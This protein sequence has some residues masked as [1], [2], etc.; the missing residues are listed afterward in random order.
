MAKGTAGSLTVS[1]GLDAVEYTR[2]L[3][4]AEYQARQLGE[5]I[6][7]SIRAGAEIAAASFATMATSAVAA[8]ATFDNLVK[9]AGD[10]QDLAEKTGASAEG[11]ASFG[12]A[13]GTAGTSVEAIAQASIKL[14]K[15]LTGVD[16]ESKAAGAAVVALGLNLKDFK[17]LSPEDQISE[18][19]KALGGFQDGAGKT[20]V[21]TALL[22][23]SGADLLPFLKALEEQGGRQVILT[24]E[25]IKQADE[26]ADQQAKAKAEL[27]QY[28]QALATQA[29]PA[30]TAFTGA[31]T[32]TIKEM[33]GIEEGAGNLAKNKGIQEF[34]DDAAVFLGGVIDLG[35]KTA[36]VF[37]FL[38]ESIGATAAIVAAASR[39]SSEGA[40]AAFSFSPLDA[41]EAA[42]RQVTEINAIIDAARERGKKFTAESVSVADQV[43]NR[44]AE[45]KRNAV[46]AAQETR[47]FTP[48]Q[49]KL[50]FDGA[51][52]DDKGKKA[53][54]SEAQRYLE[55]L[56]KQLLKA[57][58][59]TVAETALAEIRSGRIGKVSSQQEGAILAVAR[60]V[61]ATKAMTKYEELSAA[62]A[63]SRG[64]ELLKATL[65]QEEQ[66]ASLLK[67]N[68]AMRDE[69]ELIGKSAESQA[70]IEQARLSSAIAIKEEEL[71]RISNTDS[72]VRERDAIQKQIEALTE[73]KR[74]VGE[75][76]V[77]QQLEE[78]SKQ[79]AEYAKSLGSAFESSFEKV[80]FS[81][82]KV[83]DVLKA[84]LQDIGRVILRLQVTQPLIDSLTKGSSGGSSGGSS[85]FR[86]LFTAGA[87]A[88]ANASGTGIDG[89]LAA[90]NNFAGR[91]SGGPVSAGGMYE[92]NE[93]A[94]EL[95]DVNGKT[96]LMMG[97][98]SGRVTPMSGGGGDRISVVN[99]TTGRVDKFIE[100]RISPRE[101]VLILQEAEKRVFG[102]L[103]DANSRGSKAISRNFDLQRSRP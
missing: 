92:V 39:G 66:A 97:N 30:L 95:L 56:E 43:A 98:Q 54:V 23:K 78:E 22:G 16:D 71:A 42:R 64:D 21:A 67:S 99:Q 82:G 86:S 6:G 17:A 18:I 10:F 32:D 36:T 51:V 13:A 69:T 3:T 7:L 38:G 53:K 28:A 100:Q 34:A 80:V 4:K 59:L 40:K 81:G 72:Y 85:L 2:G 41:I 1:L 84:M 93:N 37:E 61:D 70:A 75:R 26:Y 45:R 9:K 90:N 25:Q 102:Q 46:L 50:R 63:K 44:I 20:A 57:R 83:S 15:N 24:A 58:E 5:K 68:E 29:L 12:T 79:A 31:I 76:G 103:S 48:G 65:T 73:R 47:G 87:A 88:Y 19:S 74:L 55:G 96:L 49:K 27:G 62:A 89:F 101:R 14:T 60:Q 8:F 94:P 33:F 35:K 52:E 11:L 77:A 91:A